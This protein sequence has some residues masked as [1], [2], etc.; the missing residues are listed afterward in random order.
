MANLQ[1]NVSSGLKQEV[2]NLVKLGLFKNESH[3]IEISLKKMFAEQSR[4]Y[5]RDLSRRLKIS[6]K[7]MLKKWEKIRK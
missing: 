1:V 4:E 3:V 6:K 5:L 2:V 7:E